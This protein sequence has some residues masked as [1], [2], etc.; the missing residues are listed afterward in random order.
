MLEILVATGN[1][2][3]IRE[4]TELLADFP[5]QLRSLN[6]FENITEPEETGVDFAANACLKARYYALKTGLWALAD[7]SG[8]EVA[9]LGG[10][11]GVFSARYAG[12]NT[13][14]AEKIEKLLDELS[15]TGDQKR[16]ARFVAVMAISDEKGTIQNL[17][18]GICDGTIAISPEGTNG[19]GYDPIFVPN[20]F[21][22]TFGELSSEIKRKISH[23]AQALEKIIRFLNDFIAVSA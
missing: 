1:A 22:E 13:S 17:S 14:H 9:A 20:G 15:K 11:P 16:L 7:D 4:I 2:G 23:R 5:I 18:E 3:K 19:F 10:A 6:E 12:E 8:L 21:N